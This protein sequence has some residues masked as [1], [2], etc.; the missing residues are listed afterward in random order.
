MFACNQ[1]LLAHNARV[2][3]Y[4]FWLATFLVMAP[5]Q[6]SGNDKLADEEED[7][8]QAVVLADSFNKRFRPLTTQKPRVSTI[9]LIYRFP[10]VNVPSVSFLFAMHNCLIGHSRVW[11]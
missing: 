10:A 6:T 3:D 4:H 8:L 1:T 9:S 11:R 5:R 7:V 2:G